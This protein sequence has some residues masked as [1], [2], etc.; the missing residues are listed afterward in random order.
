MK[1]YLTREELITCYFSGKETR[2]NAKVDWRGDVSFLTAKT[3]AVRKK[4]FPLEVCLVYIHVK[5]T[6][7]GGKNYKADKEGSH[8]KER[9]VWS[10]GAIKP[11]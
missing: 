6:A 9:N 3:K 8:H 11:H 5:R 2:G 1:D 7:V 10:D 4:S